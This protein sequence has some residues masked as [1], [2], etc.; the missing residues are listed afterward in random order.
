M[1]TLS[2]ITLRRGKTI[3]LDNVNWTIHKQQRIGIIGANGSGKTSLFALLLNELESDSGELTIPRQLTFAHVAQETPAYQET[4]LDF[5]MDGDEELR[6]LQQALT[7]AEERHDGHEIAELHEKLS[8]IDGYS[9]PARAARLLV[10]LG[11]SHEEQQKRVSDFSGGFR[12]RLNL[13]RA[14]M[15]RSDILL[16]DEPTNHLDLDA[17]IW[18]EEW[19]QSYT[20]TLLLIS[21]D[22][23]FLD[24]TVNQIVHIH[25]RQLTVYTGNYS[26]FET[27]R[28]NQLQLQQAQY[29]KQ[30]KQIAHMQAFVDRFRYKATKARQAQSRLKAI[31]RLEVVAKVQAESP[32]YFEFKPPKEC[33]YPLIYLEDAKIAYGDRVILDHLKLSISPGERITILGPN[34]AGKSSLIKLLAGELEPRSGERHASSGLKIG[35]FAQHQ[36]D[37]LHLEESPIAHLRRLTA[38]ALEVDLRK[39]LGGFG[40]SGDKVFDPVAN[41]SGGEK[42]RLA[43]ALIVWQR[44]N[45]LLLDEPTN[46][47]DLEMRNAMSIALQEY[48]GALILITHD[49]FLIRTTTDKLLLVA[50][51]KLQEFDGDLNQYQQWLFEYRKRQQ[52]QNRGSGGLPAVTNLNPV[53]NPKGSASKKEQRQLNAKAR[54]ARKPLLDKIKKLESEMQYLHEQ[55]HDIEIKLTDHD[56]YEVENKEQLQNLL[57]DEAHIK[58]ELLTIEEAWLQA[59]QKREEGKGE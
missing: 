12:V 50:D 48:S 24:H 36:V 49:R 9:A 8:I 37:R 54:E 21:H 51:G 44:P 6:H 13:A 19:L 43:L 32:F 1:I 5:V 41:F 33:P 29:E 45:L 7:L 56:L 40:F 18:L 58:K 23:D 47:L 4:A 57:L 22:R 28:A 55:L 11:F 53:V 16:L 39:F 27:E 46:H 42:S 52:Q 2:N 26:Q 15:H 20:G 30:Q 14:L 31:E 35:Y 3:L 25:H 59:C 17:V 10:G 34:G 38:S